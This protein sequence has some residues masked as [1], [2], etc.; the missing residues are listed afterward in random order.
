MVFLYSW[1]VDGQLGFELK[2]KTQTFFNFPEPFTSRS[3]GYFSSLNSM[4]SSLDHFV[5]RSMFFYFYCW[6]PGNSHILFNHL[7]APE[8]HQNTTG[9]AVCYNPGGH[10]QKQ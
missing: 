1:F 6:I 3:D 4:N 8:Q 2:L 5:M 7:K 10:Q 9:Q